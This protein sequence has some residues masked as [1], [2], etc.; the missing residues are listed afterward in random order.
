MANLKR[1]ALKLV[2]NVSDNFKNFEL[3]FNDYCIQANYHN[4]GKDPV[5]EWADHYKSPL[6]EIYA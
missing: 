6:Q 4:L 3:C 5:P 1:P 2:S